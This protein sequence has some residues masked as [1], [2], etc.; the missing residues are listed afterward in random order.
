LKLI[1]LALSLNFFVFT[2][3]VLAQTHTISGNVKDFQGG[4]PMQGV[5]VALYSKA[6]Q[7]VLGGTSSNEKGEFNLKSVFKEKNILIRFSYIGYETKQVDTIAFLN[8]KADLG[9]ILL[10]PSS[11]MKSAVEITGQKPMVEFYV[12]KQVINMDQV[13]GSQSGSVSDALRNTGIVEVD[14]S[15]SKISLRGNSNVN[16]LIDG[17]P[18]PMADNLLS[19]MPASYIDKVE[20]ITTPSAKDDPEGDAG[21]IN[22]ITKKEHQNNYNGTFA[23]YS[24][25]QQIGFLSSALNYRKGGLNLFGSVNGYYGKFLRYTD[26][27]RINYLSDILHSQNSVGQSLTRGYMSN[28]KLGV[29]YDFDTLNSL[30]LTGNYNKTNGT[31]II[32]ADNINYNLAGVETYSYNTNDD[33]HGDFNN[34]TISTDYKKKFNTKGHEITADAFFSNMVNST[35]DLLTT[36]YNYLPLYPGLQNNNNDVMNKTIILNTDYVN[37]TETFGKIEAGYKFTFRDRKATLENLNYSYFTGLY[38]DSLNLSNIFRYRENIH[39]LYLS[40]SNKISVIDYKLGIRDEQTLT[41]GVQEVTGEEFKTNYNSLFPT[42]GLA[43][44]LN[45]LFQLSFNAAR[46]INRPQLEMINPFIKVNGPNNI[47]RGNPQLAPTYT[48]SFELKFNPLLNVYYSDSKGRPSSISTNINDSITVNSTINS[49][50]NKSYGV[51]LTI[52]IINQPKFPLTLPDWFGMFNVRIAYNRFIENGSYLS[53]IYS[54]KRDSWK[55]SG[56][57]NLN[58]WWD[59]NLIFYYNIALKTE[60]DRYRTNASPF[61]GMFIKKDFLDKKLTIGLNI[62]DLFNAI[63]PVN[64]TFGSNFYSYSKSNSWRS[65]NIGLSV[66]YN[67]NDFKD[68]QDK[69]VDDGRDKDGG[70]FK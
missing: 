54:I 1:I 41:D 50:S 13:P 65:R 48:N 25:T 63:R 53:E 9:T 26:G 44:K 45:E 40:Y 39:A 12:D 18:Q 3:S 60:D 28:I 66:R 59:I 10:K 2:H 7:K 23:L 34:Y 64:E 56:N 29:D 69:E 58:L 37:P 8:N 42:F 21:I 32:S 31:M 62:N 4:T 16:I 38:Y 30:S 49:A 52:P 22:I 17:K 6:N 36:E 70:L 5:T 68:H 20:V 11:I 46:K 51:E 15:T 57:C 24:A 43:Y 47:T 55:F 33:G 27:Q 35:H 14:P 67:F 61:A 19:Q